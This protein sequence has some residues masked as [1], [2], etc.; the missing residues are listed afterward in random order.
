MCCRPF[1][2]PVVALRLVEGDATQTKASDQCE[3]GAGQPP[4]GAAVFATPMQPGGQHQ[5][6]GAA[7]QHRRAL[8]HRPNIDE[9]RRDFGHVALQ[10]NHRNHRGLHPR[11][12]A[13]GTPEER[14]QRQPRKND[15]KMA[16]QH[17]VEQ[18]DQRTPEHRRWQRID[19][20]ETSNGEGLDERILV[21]SPGR[22]A[23]PLR[24]GQR[25]HHGEPCGRRK[26]ESP[27]SK[28]HQVRR[29]TNGHGIRH[30]V[31]VR[32]DKKCAAESQNQQVDAE[33]RHEEQGTKKPDERVLGGVHAMQLAA[34][35]ERKRRCADEKKEE[36]ANA[37]GT[38]EFPHLRAKNGEHCVH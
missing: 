27:P 9:P 35:D 11:R 18:D 26:R 34:E 22:R 30:A 12:Q 32:R 16:T 19:D 6:A 21:E 14:K 5:R 17:D 13:Q 7:T 15:K 28:R 10:R 20:K 33:T 31:K 3:Q 1:L 37:S 38:P 25:G 23:N 29:R 8:Q 36:D 4:R 2:A 24:D